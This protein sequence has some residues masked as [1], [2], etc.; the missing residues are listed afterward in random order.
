MGTDETPSSI[1]HR[2]YEAWSA[3]DIAAIS[4]IVAD[5]LVGHAGASRF[6]RDDLLTFRLGLAQRF[7]RLGIRTREVV[8]QDDRVAAAWTTHGDG[9]TWHGISLYRIVDGLIAEIQDV[10]TPEPRH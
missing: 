10:R 5:G 6:A 3:G 7:D 4:D 8:A 1:V 9:G 2:Y